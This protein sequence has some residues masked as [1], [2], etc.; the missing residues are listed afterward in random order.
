MQA[1]A[2]K[3][4]D[5]VLAHEGGYVDDP[6][7]PGGATN[8]GITQDTL[9]RVRGEVRASLPEHVKQLTKPQARAI[10]RHDYWTPVAGNDL[11]GGLDLALFDMAVNQGVDDAVKALQQAA[12]SKVDGIMGPNTLAAV[13]ECERGHLYIDFHAR[14]VLDYALLKDGLIKRYGYGWFR[15]VFRTFWTGLE[16]F[17]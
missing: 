3:A 11:P 16:L 7:D 15:R 17:A 13:E 4:I 6:K 10:Y 1:N 12:G 2:R 9:E 14:R 5:M 8:M